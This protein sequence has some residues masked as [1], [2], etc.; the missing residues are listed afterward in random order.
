MTD[1]VPL[2]VRVKP[3]TMAGLKEQAE[4]QDTTV[5]ALVRGILDRNLRMVGNVVSKGAAQ[6]THGADEHVE[7]EA[8]GGGHRCI[9][10][11]HGDAAKSVDLGDAAEILFSISFPD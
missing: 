1:R 9:V 5:S 7:V 3:E 4:A 10:H 8:H 2:F 11:I 6:T